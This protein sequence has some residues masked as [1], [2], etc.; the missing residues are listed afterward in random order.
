MF[1]EAWR[2]VRRSPGFAAAVIAV[3]ALAIGAN[4]AIFAVV[5]A[6]LLQP[7]PYAYPNRLVM[8]WRVRVPGGGGAGVSFPDFRAYRRQAR[9]F[10]AMSVVAGT[11]Y[12]VTGSGPAAGVLGVSASAN[13]FHLLG[14]SPAL[15]P[16]FAPGEDQ[17]GAVAGSDAVVLSHHLWIARFAGRRGVIGQRIT[18]DGRPYTVVGVMPSG[19]A[20]PPGW[21]ADLWTTTA[22]FR[23]PMGGGQPLADRRAPPM[24]LLIMARLKPGVTLAAARAEM[25]TIGARVARRYPRSDGHTSVAVTTVRAYLSGRYP[26]RSGAP[27]GAM[28]EI[29]L[30]AAG[31]ML[32]IAA[33]DLAG[34][35]LS[36]GVARRGEMA[37]RAALGASRRRLVSELMAESLILTGL[38]GVAGL[39]LAAWLLP[40]L[41]RLS[42]L[43][44]PRLGGAHLGA[45]V[46]AFAAAA[47]MGTAVVVGWAPALYAARGAVGPRLREATGRSRTEGRRFLRLRGALVAV[48]VAVTVALLSSAALLALGLARMEAFRPGFAARNA[49]AFDVTLPSRPFPPRRAA[50]FFTRLSRRLRRLPGVT[51]AGAVTLDGYAGSTA[52]LRAGGRRLSRPGSVAVAATTPGYFAALGVGL[53]GRDFT[54]ADSAAA[55]PVAIVNRAFARRFF[56]GRKSPLGQTITPGVGGGAPRVIV[57]VAG[58]IR[59]NFSRSQLAPAAPEIYLPEAQVQPN[60][61]GLDEMSYYL[62]TPDP[63]MALVRTARR[64]LAAMDPNVPLA[65]GTS[66]RRQ[67]RASSARADFEAIGAGSF[68][69]LALLLTA[70]GLYGVVAFSVARRRREMG[71]RL[72]LGARRGQLLRRVLG[73]S[74]RLSASGAV[75]GFAGGWLA[76][77]WLA[78]A[79][80]G[81]PPARW[82]APLAAVA[83]ILIVA[84]MAA[85][86]PA[87]RAAAADPGETLRAE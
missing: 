82:L 50:A 37:V 33:A 57:G 54:R 7:L 42:P 56:P 62:R 45:P 38:G 12:T 28:L 76:Q 40:V 26:G 44:L 49:L 79:I 39:A 55:P 46:L 48:Q 27:A 52:V 84:L 19:F 34:L 68:A 17:P 61:V 59:F 78:S 31:C 4:T 23:R 80:F 63:P 15:G 9:A 29:I 14:V 66:L 1:G 77:H 81:L 60:P 75:L 74:L 35:M 85:W 30:A 53:R 2:R 43:Q 22:G 6:V 21:R 47:V 83:G 5:E 11:P 20:A 3:V 8:L 32:L 86:F 10:S 24:F 72:A 64:V 58:D 73:E 41:T 71:I 16:G 25:G 51:A 70:V 36:R 67:L 18:L 69:A 87:R 13:L 65:G